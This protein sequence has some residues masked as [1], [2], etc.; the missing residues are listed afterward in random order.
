MHPTYIC[1]TGLVLDNLRICLRHLALASCPLCPHPWEESSSQ[2]H[3]SNT[4][5]LI[6]SLQTQS[7]PPTPPHP[8]PIRLSHPGQV[9]TCPNHSK[10]LETTPVPQPILS[11]LILP[12]PFLPVETTMIKVLAHNSPSLYLMTNPG[13]SLCG[14]HGIVCP[15]LLGTV[16]NKISFQKQLFLDLLVYTSNFLWIHYISEYIPM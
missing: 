13:G 10:Q 16:S 7:L 15:L 6:Q 12:H 2:G 11:L 1:W 4:N 5:Q 8:P 14:H 9:C 3:F